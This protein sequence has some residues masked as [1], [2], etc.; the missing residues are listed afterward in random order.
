MGCLTCSEKAGMVAAAQ[1]EL[2]AAEAEETEAQNTVNEYQQALSNL[3]REQTLANECKQDNQKAS[4]AIEQ[5][6][7]IAGSSLDPNGLLA[8]DAEC[9][10][11]YSAALTESISKCESG[12]SEAQQWL[13][14]AQQRVQR[15]DKELQR[16][17]SLSCSYSCEEGVNT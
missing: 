3:N 11:N 8:S 5:V 10:E 12:L 9:L 7:T 1:A 17:N 15:A 14:R 16:V 4:T 13:T 2:T 6:G